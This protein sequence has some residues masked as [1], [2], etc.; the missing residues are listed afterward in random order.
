MTSLSQASIEITISG[1][2]RTAAGMRHLAWTMA[3]NVAFHV[4]LLAVASIIPVNSA[5]WMLS[6]IPHHPPSGDNTVQLTAAFMDATAA[7]AK[8][9]EAAPTVVM[10]SLPVSTEGSSDI[11]PRK[12]DVSPL[13]ALP[14]PRDAIAEGESLEEA[15]AQST[16]VPPEVI[17]REVTEKQPE[18]ADSVA[19]LPRE[20][21]SELPTES[22]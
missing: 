3:G 6:A 20:V 5:A 7:S 15:A 2:V 8:E 1:P 13:A 19:D 18:V 17:R 11:A 12:T 21:T 16:A 10:Q 4:S 9:Q 14:A 22:S